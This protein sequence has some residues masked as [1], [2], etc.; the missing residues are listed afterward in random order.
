[1]PPTH[2]EVYKSMTL[3]LDQTQAQMVEAMAEA[4]GLTQVEVIRSAIDLR[5]RTV[6]KD[7]KRKRAIAE[8][9]KRRARLLKAL[10]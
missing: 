2:D 3:R 8:A 1:M 5:I 9:I 10:G 4:E 6:K 7:P